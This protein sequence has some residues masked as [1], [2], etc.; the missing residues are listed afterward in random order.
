MPID[1]SYL[2]WNPV[3]VR[4]GT[5]LYDPQ[6]SKR[7]DLSWQPGDIR[8]CTYSSGSDCIGITAED[9]TNGGQ[10][11]VV[12]ERLTCISHILVRQELVLY[13]AISPS[14]SKVC[15]SLPS[16]HGGAAD[17]YLIH[18]KEDQNRLLIE[19]GIAQ[20]SIPVWFP[21]NMHVAY[22]SSH[23]QIE[24]LNTDT[25]YREAIEDGKWPAI[26]P[27]GRRIAF[28]KDNDLLVRDLQNRQS[29]KLQIKP[30]L[31]KLHLTD[32]ISW[33][34]YG[35]AI[36]FGVVAGVVGKQTNFYIID[37][38]RKRYYKSK[39]KYLSGLL[40]IKIKKPI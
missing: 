13:H 16:P 25:G 17:F 38:K 20:D 34:S 4:L 24:V 27:D 36:S 21:D 10:V 37:L 3:E 26:S 9:R 29:R 18:V 12:Y 5:S 1:S 23:G 33:S 7:V 30:L 14:G 11:V 15:Y 28:K 31:S 32:G 40:L 22:Q 2:G 8:N 39:I 35:E 6:K 19:G